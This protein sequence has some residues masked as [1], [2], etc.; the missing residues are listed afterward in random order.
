MAVVV[1]M[2]EP[3]RR[4]GSCWRIDLASVRSDNCMNGS[5]VVSWEREV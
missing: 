4:R 2:E 1:E 5:L 3:E